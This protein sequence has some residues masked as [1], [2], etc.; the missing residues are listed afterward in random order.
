[1]K[2]DQTVPNIACGAP[3]HRT[4][5][6][7]EVLIDL[8]VATAAALL[9]VYLLQGWIIFARPTRI[10]PLSL[11]PNV[12]YSVTPL[13]LE[14]P[15]GSVLSGWSATPHDNQGALRVLLYFGGRRE[16]VS[17]APH[18]AS[19]LEGWHIYTF[20]YRG[21]AGSS[22][23][24]SDSNVKRD[25][26][27]IYHHIR[28]KHANQID[29]LAIVG[30]S[31]G[32]SPAAWLARDT[33]P[34]HLVLLSPFDS[35][36]SVASAVPLLRRI[37]CLA[38]LIRHRLEIAPFAGPVRSR[39]LI[40]LAENDTLVPHRLSLLVGSR[41]QYP[42]AVHVVQGTNHATLPR[43][44]QTQALLSQHLSSAHTTT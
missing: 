11:G 19:Y 2:A 8:S 41:F 30:R 36:L 18:I 13:S 5:S 39:T 24:P 9:T 1:M 42:P 38:R 37:P 33:K 22:G 35:L 15:D 25:A 16:H 4:M 23:F 27:A 44:P 34:D 6:Y 26:Q 29:Q 10:R 7:T 28:H 31:L 12:S 20:G 43:N 40:L 14:R 17:W 21:F 32:C 3:F